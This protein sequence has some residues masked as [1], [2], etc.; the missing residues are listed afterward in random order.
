MK[1]MYTPREPHS[2][3]WRACVYKWLQALPENNAA[4]AVNRRNPLRFRDY[5]GTDRVLLSGFKSDSFQAKATT[6]QRLPLVLAGPNKGPFAPLARQAA[7]GYDNR[8][9]VTPRRSCEWKYTCAHICVRH[10]TTHTH[11]NTAACM[12]DKTEA[13]SRVSLCKLS[14]FFV[15]VLYKPKLC[16]YHYPPETSP[17]S[18]TENT[19]TQKKWSLDKNVYTLLARP[20]PI[21]LCTYAITIK[22]A[23]TNKTPAIN[24]FLASIALTYAINM[25]KQCAESTENF[26]HL[27]SL[28][29]CAKKTTSFF[30]FLENN[31][32]IVPALLRNK[33]I[34]STGKR[35]HI[36]HIP[37]GSH[38]ARA[39]NI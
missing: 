9:N 19:A 36:Q 30:I 38:E 3:I 23:T 37:T 20:Q 12:P 28:F 33:Y 22:V 32:A 15:S 31:A 26:R 4:P 6:L 17:L 35:R 8:V 13:L 7:S 25:K 14:G 27:K 24:S 10:F 11:T 18:K 29:E 34:P 16:T 39:K 1:N 5:F 2:V 21:P